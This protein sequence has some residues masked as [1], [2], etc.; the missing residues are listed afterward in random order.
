MDFAIIRVKTRPDAPTK[1]PATIKAVF[2]KR[3]PAKAAATPDNEFNNEMTTGISPPPIGTTKANPANNEAT[4]NAMNVISINS[5]LKTKIPVELNAIW[6]IAISTKKQI[7]IKNH[8]EILLSKLFEPFRISD[9]LKK[10]IKLP[11]KVTP[12]IKTVI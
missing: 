4:K 7:N 2:N 5:K 10:A 1:H 3:T 12:P 6:L 9:S 11:E 8:L